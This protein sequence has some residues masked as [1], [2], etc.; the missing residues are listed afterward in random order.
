MGV[1]IVDIS[2]ALHSVPL[3]IFNLPQLKLLS[4]FKGSI[5]YQRILDYNLPKDIDSNDTMA[6]HDWFDD[7]FLYSADVDYYLSLNP[8]CEEFVEEMDL[9]PFNLLVFLNQTG[10]CDYRY[11]PGSHLTSLFCSPWEIGD[12]HCHK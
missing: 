5:D 12:G 7:N 9:L 11:N 10:V 3:S 2:L 6:V 4:L 8:I 1:L